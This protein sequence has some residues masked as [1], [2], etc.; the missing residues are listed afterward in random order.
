MADITRINIDD[1]P[2]NDSKKLRITIIRGDS[3]R[4]LKIGS[5]AHQSF[6]DHKDE[7]RKLRYI[8]RHGP[9]EDWTPSGVDTAGFWARAILWNLPT[10]RE[11]AK[12][13]GQLLGAPIYLNG[14]PVR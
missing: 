5:R 4:T 1:L 11:S 10:L 13:T 14:Q 2:P 8:K 7:T 3:S 6:P 9:R 12:K